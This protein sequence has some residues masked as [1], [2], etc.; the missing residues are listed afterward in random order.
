MALI[1][2]V[3]PAVDALRSQTALNAMV[4]L[5]V[6]PFWLRLECTDIICMFLYR[7]RG[8][9]CLH[10]GDYMRASGGKTGVFRSGS[11]MNKR[12]DYAIISPRVSLCL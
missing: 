7:G 6:C 5:Q 10:E 11:A 9:L 4:L 3:V 2:A 1:L 12:V 8:R